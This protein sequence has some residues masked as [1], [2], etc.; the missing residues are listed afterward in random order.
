MQ[1]LF[2]KAEHALQQG[3]ALAD[4]GDIHGAITSFSQAL[5]HLETIKP[6]RRRDQLLADVYLSRYQ[7]SLNF[8]GPSAYSDLRWGYS[9][10]KTS[11]D[12]FL[13][14]K[15]EQLWQVFLQQQ[16]AHRQR[17]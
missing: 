12:L 6:Q 13:R 7:V 5:K 11:Q 9:Y 2:N 4:Q 1:E 17:H 3:H 14:S 15:A 8:S 16:Q 10:A